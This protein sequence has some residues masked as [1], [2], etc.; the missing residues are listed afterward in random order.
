MNRRRRKNVARSMRIY[1]LAREKV[2]NGE[3]PTVIAEQLSGK[4]VSR[5][6]VKRFCL[7]I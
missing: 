3:N 4:G 7:D 1:Y 5:E 6:V 2:K